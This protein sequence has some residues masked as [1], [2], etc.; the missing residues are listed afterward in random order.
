MT[1]LNVLKYKIMSS[2][3]GHFKITK[4]YIF[5]SYKYAMSLSIES[6]N[7]LHNCFYILGLIQR[8]TVIH[9]I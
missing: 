9:S 8:D 3:S 4:L 1:D 5:N 6:G 2:L 7:M